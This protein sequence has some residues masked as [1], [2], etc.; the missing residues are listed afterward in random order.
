MPRDRCVYG[1]GVGGNAEQSSVDISFVDKDDIVVLS[2]G[3]NVFLH[4]PI[5]HWSKCEQLPSPAS[6]HIVEKIVRFQ[7]RQKITDFGIQERC[8]S[9]FVIL[10]VRSPEGEYLT[11]EFSQNIQPLRE[12]TGEK[13]LLEG[14]ILHTRRIQED[15]SSI[16]FTAESFFY[17]LSMEAVE[18][19]YVSCFLAFCKKCVIITMVYARIICINNG[20][21][22]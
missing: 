14:N 2:Q 12:L 19:S 5:G 21:K 20:S 6:V 15:G 17:L 9:S 13:R 1:Q 22:L 8:L 16:F 4:G 11:V 3:K 7:I 18:M 10:V